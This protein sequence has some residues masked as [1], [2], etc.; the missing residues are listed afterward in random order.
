MSVDNT[1]LY[2]NSAVACLGDEKREEK[3][4]L[5]EFKNDDGAAI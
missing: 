3:T 1:F 5:K 4:Q 2:F